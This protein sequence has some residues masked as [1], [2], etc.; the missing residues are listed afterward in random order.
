MGLFS[1]RAPYPAMTERAR[2]DRST[3]ELIGICRGVLADGSVNLQEARFL[4]DWLERH[5]EFLGVYPFNALHQRIQ[6]AMFDGVLD[7]E[8]ERDLLDVLVRMVGGE[9]HAAGSSASLSTALPFDVPP[10]EIIFPGQ[11]FAVTGV[12]AFGQRKD[13]VE[14]IEHRGGM[15]KPS[16]SGK[17]RFLVIGEIGSRD[18]AHS[19]F[20]RK[21]EEA[22]ALRGDGE[23]LSIV[24]EALW[25]KSLG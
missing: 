8:E 10:P 14:A 22:I 3:D 2:Q 16:V 21:I 7:N 4:M 6:G 23:N 11:A 19:C 15:V 24:S 12:F 5:R 1:S 18:W 20:G 13:V 17:V 25:Q 9:S